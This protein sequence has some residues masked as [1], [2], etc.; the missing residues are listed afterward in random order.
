MRVVIHP[1]AERVARA[2]ARLVGQRLQ[3]QPS[4]VLALPT[5]RTAIPFYR[6]LV[7]RH[8]AG[9]APFRRVSTFN[10]DE[11]LGVGPRDAGS[12]ASYMREHLFAHVDLQ[13]G[14]RHLLNGLAADPER[15]AARF[16]RALAR[17]GGLDVA[18]LGIGGNGHIGF[19]E[20]ARGLTARTHVVR[21]D[22]SSR[23]ANAY[24][25]AGRL[26][27]V[28]SRALTMGV[29]TI[30]GARTVV[31]MATGAGKRAI[32]RRALLGPVTTDVPASLLQAHPDVIV[33]VDR[34]AGVDLTRSRRADV[35]IERART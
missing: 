13:E 8:Q 34:A 21:L 25:F 35:M 23:R 31:L 19:N 15:E 26:S 11:F 29:G 12:Y 22:A 6:A 1:D 24:L 32:V 9:R 3:A 28:P 5:G 10:L 30:L 16:E 14:R 2:I 18:V 7:E 33:M 27:R 4:S 17:A 20:P